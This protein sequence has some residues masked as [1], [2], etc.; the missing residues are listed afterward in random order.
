MKMDDRNYGN[1]IQKCNR[2]VNDIQT[3]ALDRLQQIQKLQN[4]MDENNKAWVMW[5]T[6]ALLF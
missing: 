3:I 5:F 2:Y 6:H 1:I 4:N